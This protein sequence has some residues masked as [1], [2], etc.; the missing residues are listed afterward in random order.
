MSGRCW[1]SRSPRCFVKQGSRSAPTIISD[2]SYRY[3]ASSRL[4]WLLPVYNAIDRAL[5]APDFMK[6]LRSFVLTYGEKP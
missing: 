2:L 4:R 5:F 1:R 6:P 3:V